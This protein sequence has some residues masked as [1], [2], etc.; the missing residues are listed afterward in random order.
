[1]PYKHNAARRYHIPKMKYQVRNWPAYEA[2]LRRRG[3]LTLWIEQGAL[4][5]WQSLGPGGQARYTAKAIETCLMLRTAF[6]LPLRQAEGLMASVVTLMG[7]TISVPD[8]STVSRRAASLPVIASG[9]LPDG[10]LHVLIDSTGLAVY[11]AGQW[12][13]EKHGRKSRR[14]W[15][16]LHLAVDADSGLIVAQTLTDQ[17]KD[18]PSQVGP[19]L[20]QVAGPIARVTADGAYDGTPT[21]RTLTEHSAGVAVVIPPRATAVRSC[22]IGPPSQR[23][24]HLETI[25][26]RGRLG[27]QAATGYGQ[28]ARV[29]TTMGRYKALIGPRLRAR[30]FAAQQTEAAIGV[31]ALNRM[32]GAG[33]PDSVRRFTAAP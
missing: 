1:M 30:G 2:G 18:D 6:K 22:E 27:W 9:S 15:R 19:L 21:Y 23:D 26:A 25:A 20:D 17:D 24:R 28:R 32:L 4:E 8:H 16:K 33:R 5:Q 31:A 29:E 12:L 14:G 11:G 13:E 10:P 3:S 7:R